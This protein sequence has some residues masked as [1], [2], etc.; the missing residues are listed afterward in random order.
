M[1]TMR[2]VTFAVPP[3][4]D[5]K[6]LNLKKTSRH[7]KDSYSEVV[8]QL[9]QKGLDAYRRDKDKAANRDEGR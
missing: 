3:D 8:R 4:L 7:A 9:V 2:R 5:K 6:I 1:T